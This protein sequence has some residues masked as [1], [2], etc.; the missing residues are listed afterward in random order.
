MFPKA[1]YPLTEEILHNAILER[2]QPTIIESEGVIAGFAN[3]Y[4]WAFDGVCSIGN[5]IVNPAMRHRGI[6]EN[7][8]K[9][10]I[11]TAKTIYQASEIHISCFNQ[12][13]NGLLLYTRLGFIPYRIEERLDFLQ[14]RVALIHMKLKD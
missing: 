7:I 9:H 1:Q 2:A 10:M 3:F 8:I 5:V 6:G 13:V 14:R 4:E 12:N 11:F